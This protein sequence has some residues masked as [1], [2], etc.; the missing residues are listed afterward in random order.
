MKKAVVVI[1]I[2]AGI[3]GALIGYRYVGPPGP[4]EVQRVIH[5]RSVVDPSTAKLYTTI[6]AG[7]TSLSAAMSIVLLWIYGNLY[8]KLRSEF[9]LG[10]IVATSALLVYAVTANP[11]F[12]TLI[13]HRAIGPGPVL[14]IPDFFITLALAVLLYLALK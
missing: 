8:R 14:V 6:K 13:G 7:L 10:L 4:G 12:H 3:L 1:I 2:A 5:S 9:T 11:I